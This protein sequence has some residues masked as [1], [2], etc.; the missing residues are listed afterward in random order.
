MQFHRSRSKFLV[1]PRGLHYN[2]KCR[3]EWYALDITWLDNLTFD[4]GSA[5]R[6]N[7]CKQTPKRVLIMAAYHFVHPESTATLSLA[8]PRTIRHHS[9]EFPKF[10]T[11]ARKIRCIPPLIHTSLLVHFTFRNSLTL[12]SLVVSLHVTSS[13]LFYHSCINPRYIYVATDCNYN[14]VSQNWSK[15]S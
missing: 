8:K 11:V 7:M 3:N 2:I 4:K 14:T 1:A 10:L 9:E 15:V 5:K 13:H 6:T 12:T